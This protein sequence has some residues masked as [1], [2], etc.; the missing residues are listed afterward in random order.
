[1]KRLTVFICLTALLTVA[2][3]HNP[4]K[5]RQLVIFHAGSLSLPMKALA[6]SFR[7]IYPETEFLSEAS[8][9]LDCA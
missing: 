6:D 4:N 2:G 5:S 7:T 1:M 3:C 9:S 8:G